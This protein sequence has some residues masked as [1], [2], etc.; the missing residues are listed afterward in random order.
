M[1]RAANH[2]VLDLLQE[3]IPED[4]LELAWRIAHGLFFV[5][6][7]GV[8]GFRLPAK[9]DLRMAMTKC[10]PDKSANRHRLGT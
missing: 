3:K 10:L 4:K 8:P 7:G 9:Q 2:K 5:F 1:L 6:F